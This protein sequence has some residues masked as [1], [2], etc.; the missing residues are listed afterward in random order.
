MYTELDVVLSNIK[1]FFGGEHA[2][3]SVPVVS[4]IYDA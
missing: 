4:P 3:D 2:V 1:L